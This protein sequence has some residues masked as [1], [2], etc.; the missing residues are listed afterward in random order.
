M[1]LSVV[2]DVLSDIY[3]LD[4][5]SKPAGIGIGSEAM[6]IIPS[7]LAEI[8]SKFAAVFIFYGHC[9]AIIGNYGDRTVSELADYG[10]GNISPDQSSLAA[11]RSSGC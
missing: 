5:V 4:R 2:I 8:I 10:T 9:F 6:L 3:T 7:F 11:F 1:I